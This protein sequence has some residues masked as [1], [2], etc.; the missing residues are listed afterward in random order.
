MEGAQAR[1]LSPAT[2]VG[3]LQDMRCRL[4]DKMDELVEELVRERLRWVERSKRTRTHT[5]TRKTQ[6]HN[7]T[8][9]G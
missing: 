6:T 5:H 3:L 9:D 7:N 1:P 2:V 8:H 4:Q